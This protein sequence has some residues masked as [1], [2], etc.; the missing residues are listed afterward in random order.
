M[1]ESLSRRSTRTAIE[2]DSLS[3]RIAKQ[4]YQRANV[5]QNEYQKVPLPKDFFDVAVGNVPFA[6]VKVFDPNDKDLNK[7]NLSLHDYYFAKAISQ[8]RPGGIVAFITSRYTMDKVNGKLRDYL[9]KQAD[10]LGAIRL[11]NTQFKDIA[12]TE[13]TTDIIVLQKREPDTA[14]GGHPWATVKPISTA[15]GEVTANEYFAAHPE[16]IMGK[17]SLQ[18]SMYRDKEP[19]V[20]ADGRD[21]A[22]ALKEAFSKLPQSV[23][24][25]RPRP[26]SSTPRGLL[27]SL[28]A[29]DDVKNGAYTIQNNALYVREGDK[30]IPVEDATPTDLERAKGLIGLREQ[31]REVFKTQL[32]NDS[33]QAITAARKELN[34]RYD[35]FVKKW[36]PI[37]GRTNKS[38]FRTDPD[39]STLQALEKD[40]DPKTQKAKKADI[41]SKRVIEYRAKVTT[42]GSPKEALL[43]SMNETGTI[44]W[45]RMA[46]LTGQPP[47]EM[48]SALK[49]VVYQ[50]PAGG[51]DMAANYLSGNVRQKLK[52]AREAAKIDPRY[53]ENVE[54]LEQI[55]PEDLKPDQIHMKMGHGWV[56][57]DVYEGFIAHLLQTNERNTIVKYNAQVG[58]YS[59]TL[60]KFIDRTRNVTTFGTER[61]PAQEL[62]HDALHSTMPTVYDRTSDD[63]R[64]VNEKETLAAREKLEA[65]QE[66]FRKWVW[67]DP[68]RTERLARLYNDEFNSVVETKYDGSHLT[69]PGANPLITL[70]PHQKNVI[71]RAL[72]SGNTLLAHVVGAG[73]TFAMIGIALESRRLRLANKPMIA[74]PNHLVEQWRDSV[75]ALYPAAKVLMATKEDFKAEN[76]KR[77]VGRIATGDWDLVVIAHSQLSRVPISVESFEQFVNEQ[78]EI[79]EDYI[80][81]AKAESGKQSR[82]LTKEL[83]KAKKRLQAKLERRKAEVAE[84]ADNAVNFE[85]TGV[86]ML[87]IDEADLFKNLWFPTRMTRVA[88]LPNSESQRSYDLFLKTQ[89][90][91]KMT[92]N[93]GVIFATG[94]PVSNSMAEVFTMQRYLQ[95]HILEQAGLTHFDA[96]ARQFGNTVTS[97]ELSPDGSGYRPRTRFAEFVNVPE[98]TQ[99]FRQVMDVQGAEHLNLP[100]PKLRTGK[101]INMVAKPSEA[102]KAYTAELIKRADALKKGRV[103]PRKDNMLKITGDGRNAAL[104]V[105]LRVP[106][107]P[108]DKNSKVVL[109]INQVVEEWKRTKDVQGTQLVFL[110]LSTPKGEGKQKAGEEEPVDTDTELGEEIAL[111]GAS[112]R[113]S[114][115]S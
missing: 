17:L 102:L 93:R 62:I 12:N 74:V 9:S 86:D 68:K 100:V 79:L 24:R 65:I 13:V 54:A 77:L 55:I 59:V 42:A 104:D 36:G 40:F 69:L 25:P 11:P 114:S 82:N 18:G 106:D 38:L 19:T 30:F 67:Q 108:E 35:K 103:D 94:T 96:W 27:E 45:D 49:G 98:L 105:R 50:D 21:M 16:Q 85:E 58:A 41:F 99:M 70:R 3:A 34:A 14:Y 64:V 84:R 115:A 39:Y 43:A 101:P 97:M 88:G 112:I 52:A 29:T 26:T 46:E 95:P 47:Q 5:I 53:Q 33:E 78:V 4:L 63:K 72:Q 76:R 8:V 37:N 83:E 61:Y 87:L 48:Q 113:T 31:V 90:L 111:R 92:K 89:Y 80:R 57:T 1:P 81:E 110:D 10:L 107:A 75:M 2:L 6:D 60:P 28:Q 71:W 109:M 51:W 66:E 73:K 7:L 15:D 22:T 56:P 91:N 44:D 20:Q 32:A 23:M